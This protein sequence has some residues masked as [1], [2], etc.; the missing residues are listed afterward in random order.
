MD[1]LL[2]KKLASYIHETGLRALDHLAENAGQPEDGAEPDALQTLLGHW[3]SMTPEQ[4]E[5]F[6]TR[7]STSVGEVIAASAL[8]PI[9]IK[10]GKKAVKSAKKVL[11]KS[12]RTLKKNAK[13]AKKN[14]K[15]KSAKS[16]KSAAPRPAKKSQ[17]SKAGASKKRKRAV[18]PGSSSSRP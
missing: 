1:S 14:E 12:A 15:K 13:A 4:K 17:R 10:V 9:G 18:A 11:K 16:V 6:V 5:S 7:V 2:P 8:L 3:R